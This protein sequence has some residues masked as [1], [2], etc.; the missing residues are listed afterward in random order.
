VEYTLTGLGVDAERPLR[1]L[2]TWV[3]ANI[4]RFPPAA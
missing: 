2:R 4:E 1:E 3:E